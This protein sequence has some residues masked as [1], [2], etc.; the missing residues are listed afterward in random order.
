MFKDKSKLESLLNIKVRPIF[1]V[2]LL[3]LFEKNTSWSDHKQVIRPPPD[4][5]GGHLNY[6]V[7]GYDENMPLE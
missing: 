2:S 6:E 4:V 5:V 7:R 1:Q 3:K